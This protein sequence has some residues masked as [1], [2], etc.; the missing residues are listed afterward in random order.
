MGTYLY[1]LIN[2]K[3]ISDFDLKSIEKVYREIRK[4]IAIKKRLGTL[5]RV[6]PICQNKIIFDNFRGRGYGDDP[7]YICEQLRTKEN[8]DLVW[9]SND[10]KQDKEMIGKGVRVVPYGSLRSAY[11]WATAAVWVD[12]V[13]NT[14]RP[15]K[16]KKQFYIQTW[17]SCLGLKKNEADAASKLSQSYK[18]RIIRDAAETDL[19]YSNNDFRLNKYKNRYWYHGLV[20]KCSVPR[21]TPLIHGQAAAGKRIRELYNI[22]EDT[23][24]VLYAPTFRHSESTDVYQLDRS[25]CLSELTKKGIGGKKEF[26]CMLRLHPNISEKGFKNSGIKE[27]DVSEYPDFTE[28]LA[29]ADVLI[30]DYSG[31]IFDGM[32]AKKPVF[33]FTPDFEEYVKND[34]G[35]VFTEEEMPVPFCCKEEELWKEIRGFSSE[36]YEEK[37]RKFFSLVGLCDDGRGDEYIARL[38]LNRIEGGNGAHG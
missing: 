22:A 37:C 2:G 5:F 30:S 33:L 1:K 29:A 31:V 18:E 36:Q 12:N 32:L 8:L 24:I 3:C 35:L 23:G 38:I 28:L 19:M 14:Q 10:P 26:I 15:L 20:I 7:K 34:R 16:R 11:E 21:C 27:L 9:M 6:F 4:K 25:R 17:H 13:K